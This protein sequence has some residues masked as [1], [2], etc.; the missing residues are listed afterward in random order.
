MTEINPAKQALPWLTALAMFMQALDGTILNTALPAIANDFGQSSLEMQSVIV[1]YTVTLAILIPLSG[2]LAD[3]YGTRKIFTLSVIIF[4]LGSLFCGLSYDL[5]ALVIS[6]IIQA[7]GGAMMVPVARL[8]IL[9]SYPKSQLLRVMN[10]ITIPGLVGQVI[11]PSLGGFLSDNY[12]WH[13][14]FLINLPIGCIG[15]F[16][17]TKKMPNLSKKVHKFDSLGLFYISAII[18]ALTLIME[19][20]SIGFT[21]WSI[22]SITLLVTI[23]CIICY[24]KHSKKTTNP[25]IDLNLFKIDTLRIGLLGNLFTRLGIGGMPLLLPLMLQVGYGHSASV[26]G[27]LLIPSAIANVIAKSFVVPLVRKYG[28]KTVLISNTLILAFI[29]AMFSLTNSQ[30]PLIYFVP[31][32]VVFGAANSIQMSAMN[33]ITI[34]DLT[35]D[36]VSSGNSLLAIMQQ[37][38]N[39]FG[40]SIAA[41]LLS[42]ITQINL[43]DKDVSS[44][45]KFTFIIIGIITALSC[46]IFMKLNKNAGSDLSGHLEK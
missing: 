29:I 9:Y 20:L 14:I 1:S 15:Y 46:F 17:A 34:A 44:A 45:F 22:I 11:G 27:M 42:F 18:V 35:N 7:I 37:L 36:N 21:Q 33:T 16:I 32:L 3:K 6:R 12:S 10:F 38:S 40:V 23:I 41:L 4:T 43:F 19:F 25:I 8:A 5:T 2:W 13:W 31:L 26:S 39:S 24:I 30:T 28:Y